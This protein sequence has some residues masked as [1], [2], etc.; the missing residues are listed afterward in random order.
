MKKSSVILLLLFLLIFV[1]ILVFRVSNRSSAYN[2][3]IERLLNEMAHVA[4][5][6]YGLS[7][8]SKG[9]AFLNDVQELS[10]SFNSTGRMLGINESRVLLLECTRDCIEVVNNDKEIRPFLNHYPFT[11]NGLSIGISFYDD[12]TNRVSPEYIARVSLINGVI[13]YSS[14]REQLDREFSETYGEARGIVEAERELCSGG[15]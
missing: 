14:Y 11:E 5:S 7:C 8:S 15:G 12:Y 2:V 6:K 3:S 10:L 1:C 9:G 4:K 13:Y